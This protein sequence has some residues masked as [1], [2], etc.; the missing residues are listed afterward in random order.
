[1]IDEYMDF[2]E[3]LIYSNLINPNLPDTVCD[4]PEYFLQVLNYI[5]VNVDNPEM[6]FVK[7]G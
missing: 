4:S 1:M 2:E 3:G 5:G 7:Q 6:L